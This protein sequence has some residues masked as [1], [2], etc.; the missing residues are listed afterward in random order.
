M[1]NELARH[2]AGCRMIDRSAKPSQTSRRSRFSRALSKLL[3]QWGSPIASSQPAIDSTGS[4]F[5]IVSSDR[6]IEL[7]SGREPVPVGFGIAPIRDRAF[8]RRTSQRVR[9]Y[10]GARTQPDESDPASEAARRTASLRWREETIETPWVVG[11]DGAHS[12]TRHALGIDFEGAQDDESFI[13]ADV[14]LESDL[15]RDRVH[16]FL[17]DDGLVGV[18]PFFEIVGVLWPTSLRIRATNLARRDAGRSAG[19]ARAPRPAAYRASDPDW[20]AR[21]HISHRKVREFRR[22]RVFLARDAAHI[23]A[24]QA[25]RG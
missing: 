6:R 25:D 9:D 7:T 14:Q 19:S 21:F 12:T 2:G 18:I 11:C 17:G 23:T 1:A 4:P 16:L 15:A 5:I 8:A 10:R 3:R 22:L 20:M 24:R 13:L